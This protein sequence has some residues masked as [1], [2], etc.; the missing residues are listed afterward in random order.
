M[1]LKNLSLPS[2]LPTPSQV[3]RDPS[4]AL[5]S[6]RFEMQGWGGEG[7]VIGVGW[8]F[9]VSFIPC[10]SKADRLLRGGNDW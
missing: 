7:E 10:I 1:F 3:G 4:L 5:I 9:G 8:E 6:H 2:S